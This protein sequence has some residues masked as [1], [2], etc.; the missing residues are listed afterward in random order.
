MTT[1]FFKKDFGLTARESAA[2]LIGAH[3]FGTFNYEV[4]QHDDDD[5]NDFKYEVSQHKYDWT[6]NQASML[7]NQ[8]FRWA[9]SI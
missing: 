6:K 1:D 5:D 7:N 8:L 3:S 9:L 4:S 2:L